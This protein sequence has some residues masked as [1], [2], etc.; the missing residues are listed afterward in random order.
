[1]V[2]RVRR[3]VCVCRWAGTAVLAAGLALA[4]TAPS[5]AA[6]DARQGPTGPAG[7]QAKAAAVAVASTGQVL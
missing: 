6:S 5:A 1:M 7:V 3:S 4:V 2:A